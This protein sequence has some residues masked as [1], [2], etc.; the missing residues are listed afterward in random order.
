M[1]PTRTDVIEACNLEPGRE[2]L[3]DYPPEI[4]ANGAL[5]QDL[6]ARLM[7]DP[8]VSDPLEAS[9]EKIAQYADFYFEY[10]SERRVTKEVISGGQQTFTLSYSESANAD[11]YNSWK[12]RTVETLP[13][14]SQRI[15]YSNF[16]GQPMLKI[17]K[18]GDGESYEFFKYNDQAQLI[19]RA[20]P[21]AVTGY[22]DQYADLLH[23]SS[24]EYE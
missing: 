23:Q 5:L 18:L 19:L 2:Q 17:H 6:Y 9:D 7:A 11:G 20:E 3:A 14:G 1:C 16:V 24:G 15:V 10:D 12:T 8:Q 4:R 13:D 21:S 22:N